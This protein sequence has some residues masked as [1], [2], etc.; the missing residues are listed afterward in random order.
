[1]KMNPAYGIQNYPKE[2]TDL[3]PML[4]PDDYLDTRRPHG[5]R[6]RHWSLN[7][8]DAGSKDF[9]RAVLTFLRKKVPRNWHV[10]CDQVTDNFRVIDP[11]DFRVLA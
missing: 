1:M 8:C 5:L 6:H 9:T 11:A 2:P 7:K 3:T 4:L 10:Y